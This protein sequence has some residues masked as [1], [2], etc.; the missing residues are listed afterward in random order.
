MVGG[1]ETIVLIVNVMLEK[2]KADFWIHRNIKDLSKN[3]EN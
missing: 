2:Q 1:G 3:V